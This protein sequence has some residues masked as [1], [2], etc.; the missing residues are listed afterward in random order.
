MILAKEIN[1]F[2]KGNYLMGIWGHGGVTI[3]PGL[4]LCC[5][6]SNLI[7]SVLLR[8]LLHSCQATLQ[9]ET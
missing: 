8:G 2:R 6:S 1:G 4:V 9:E 7:V 3:D 5:Q